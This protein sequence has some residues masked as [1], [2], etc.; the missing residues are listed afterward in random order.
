[1]H[2]AESLSV[3]ALVLR[4]AGALGFAFIVNVTVSSSSWKNVSGVP[5]AL[6]LA[7]MEPLLA[8]E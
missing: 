5:N 8:P 1:M 3:S 6:I 4:V 2:C 7:V